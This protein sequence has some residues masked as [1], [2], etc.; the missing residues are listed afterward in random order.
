[1]IVYFFNANFFQ[2]FINVINNFFIYYVEI[3]VF[4]IINISI[5][6]YKIFV[7]VLSEFITVNIIIYNLLLYNK[8]INN[9]I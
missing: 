3:L 1:M 6:I 5:Y 4:N 2:N 8:T 9:I 7:K